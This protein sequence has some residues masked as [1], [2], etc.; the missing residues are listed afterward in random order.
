LSLPPLEACIRKLIPITQRSIS[1]LILFKALILIVI[2][3]I[4]KH[5]YLARRG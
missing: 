5:F 4:I 1:V 2:Y 3:W